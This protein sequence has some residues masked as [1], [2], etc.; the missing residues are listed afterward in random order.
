MENGGAT[1]TS[2]NQLLAELAE[3]WT[4]PDGQKILPIVAGLMP[5]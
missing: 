5:Q 4:G 1:I 3:S 2:I